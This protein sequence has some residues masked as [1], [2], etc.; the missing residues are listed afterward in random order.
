MFEDCKI[1]NL[2]IVGTRNKFHGLNVTNHDSKLV[3]QHAKKC[4]Y[5]GREI[6]LE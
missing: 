6:E 4:D 3:T 1:D 5:S 2:M